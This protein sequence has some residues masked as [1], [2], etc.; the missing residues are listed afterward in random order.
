MTIVVGF[1]VFGAVVAVAAYLV[2][3]EAGRISREPPPALFDPEDAF[4]WVVAQLPDDAA[5]TLTTGDVRRILDF[6][7]EFFHR[8]GV[9]RNGMDSTAPGPVVVGGVDQLAY[10]VERAAATG[11]AYLPEQVQAVIDTQLSYLREIGAIGPPA[12]A[13]RDDPGESPRI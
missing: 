7:L 13:S 12:D 8:T 1:F 3:R 4:D 9:A 11:E 5:A 10:I 6:Q 2:V